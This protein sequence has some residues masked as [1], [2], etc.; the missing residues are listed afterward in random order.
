LYQS[1]RGSPVTKAVMQVDSRNCT[2]LPVLAAVVRCERNAQAGPS[3]GASG[4]VPV[5]PVQ[6]WV[7]TPAVGP[8]PGVRH[9]DQPSLRD[10]I[11][12]DVRLWQCLHRTH[13]RHEEG[14]A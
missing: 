2:G 10:Y 3:D 4:E 1:I 8:D 12:N 9:T 14:M 6:M 5:M 7:G 13:V 11:R